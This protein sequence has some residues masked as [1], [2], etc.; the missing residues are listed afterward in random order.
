MYNLISKYERRCTK[1]DFSNLTLRNTK[2]EIRCTHK[3][4]VVFVK[5]LSEA[6]LIA[7]FL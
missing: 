4:V 7:V 2:D 5:R 3:K 1:D 6:I